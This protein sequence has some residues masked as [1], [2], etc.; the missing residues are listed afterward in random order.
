MGSDEVLGS[1]FFELLEPSIG[2]SEPTLLLELLP[3]VGTCLAVGKAELFVVV[4]KIV[5]ILDLVVDLVP[6][7]HFSQHSHINKLLR[8]SLHTTIMR[9]NG[10]RNKS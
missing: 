9:H 3:V 1:L 6:L 2:L 4:D 5:V 8:V 10:I 7:C